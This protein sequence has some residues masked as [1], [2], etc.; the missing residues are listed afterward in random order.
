M[1]NR[2][3]QFYGQGYGVSD[4]SIVVTL[5]G[6]TVF[7]GAVPTINT[8]ETTKTAEQ[9]VLL[10]TTTVDTS[11][12]GVKP[13]TVQAT[14]GK[15]VLAQ[16]TADFAIGRNPAYTDAQLAIVNDPD[17]TNEVKIA[18]YQAVAPSMTTEDLAVLQNS[19][20]TDV[21]ARRA[22]LAK[23]NII[24]D[25]TGEGVFGIVSFADPK[26]NVKLNGIPETKID[27]QPAGEYFWEISAPDTLSYDLSINAPGNT[28][29][30]AY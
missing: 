7:T 29:R 14:A 23:Y 11:V 6:N 5:D 26:S 2:T 24:P 4:A 30:Y 19:A 12:F 9:Q 18:V 27:G 22:I 8:A 20:T 15:V 16:T 17:A 28:D 10:F 25:S 3:L 21:V 13:M 1:A